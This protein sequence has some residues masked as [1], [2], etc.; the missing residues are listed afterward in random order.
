MEP[1]IWDVILL[2]KGSAARYYLT[3]VDR[4]LFPNI[5]VIGSEDPW[6][7]ERGYDASNPNN[8]VNYIN[9]TIDMIESFD[10][11]NVPFSKELVD[12]LTFAERT[13]QIID[14][15][16]TKVVDSK[17]KDVKISELMIPALEN[18]RRISS[19]HIRVYTITVSNGDKYDGK[20]V[21]VATG[22][23]AHR[24]PPEVAGLTQSH[25][26]HVMDM[27]TFARNPGK[28][29]N[30]ETKTM[31]IHGP[32]AA[33]DTADTAKFQ[34]FNVVWLVKKD[35]K[36]ALLA[37]GHQK[38]AKSAADNDVKYYPDLGR[39]VASFKVT[40]TPGSD[41]PVTV[42]LENQVIKG[43]LYVYGMGQ[44][45]DEA[46]KNVIPPELR[47]GLVPI[48]DINQR[49]GQVHETVLGFKLENL[50]WHNGFEVIGSICTQVERMTGG[51]KHTYLKD[52]SKTILKDLAKT[53]D[54]VRHNV[55]QHL[56]PLANSPA[57]ILFDKLEDMAR[58]DC[59]A[60]KK[61][62]K[63]ALGSSIAL[64]PS[65]KDHLTAV[66]NLLINYVVAAK[67]FANKKDK[68][69]VVDADL[70]RVNSILTPSTVAHAQLGGIRATTAAMNGFMTGTPNFSQDDRTILRFMIAVK[71]P[72]VSEDDA[73]AIIS[74]IITGR[75][76]PKLGGYGYSQT[77]KAA[78]EF[79]LKAA[80]L[81]GTNPLTRP[82]QIGTGK[83]LSNEWMK[84]HP[85]GWKMETEK[86]VFV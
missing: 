77:Q 27:N 39:G 76:H 16:A 83:S 6:A 52:L 41:K 81:K 11:P 66:A 43:D 28:F 61:Q 70:D 8:P 75:K 21:V 31:F 57:T 71:Y 42:F 73:Q 22:A 50:D 69:K 68:D 80:N 58:L 47:T 19:G 12:R 24:E 65:W 20:K 1:D 37:T 4:S 7:G 15:Y 25:P 5:L 79:Q 62:I 84:K 17:A 30:P 44:D 38:F 54:E 9:Q 18:G 64:F 10:N 34:K 46:V 3:T 48:Y 13:R 60:A 63:E 32:N 14:S 33:I 72:F 26:N 59:E 49:Y 74:D 23:G 67:F 2:G 51:V 78:F 53:T 86:R 55:L 56:L 36:I 40:V 85:G 82:K 35:T 45:A 29:V